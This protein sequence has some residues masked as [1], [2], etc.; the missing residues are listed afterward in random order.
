MVKKPENDGKGTSSGHFTAAYDLKSADDTK[1][2]YKTWAETYDQ[3][4]GIENGYA[5]PARTAE[6][7]QRFQ[8]DASCLVLDAG[9]GSG[10]SGVALKEAGYENLHGCDFSPE[11][12]K[13]S[14]DKDCYAN[15]FLADLNKGQPDIADST[16][17]CVTCV[18][19]FS[20]AHVSPNACDD[21]L[22]ILKPGGYL[23]IALNDPFWKK[24]DLSKKLEQ[25]E[26]DGKLT[27]QSKEFGD[28][29]PGHNVSGWVICGQKPSS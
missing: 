8:P 17:D 21:L 16:Y 26:R 24:G 5:Q 7:L 25:L 19:V 4:V 1:A 2:Y 12:L 15:L 20:F 22:R 27:I 18:G 13:K 28:H 14:L 10:L 9:C 6:M 29:L 11:M 3:E 23:I